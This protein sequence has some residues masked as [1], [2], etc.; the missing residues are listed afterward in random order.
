MEY[1]ADRSVGLYFSVLFATVA[2]VVGRGPA[3]SNL[4]RR[5][6]TRSGCRLPP[7]CGICGIGRFGA[8]R[9]RRTPRWW[10]G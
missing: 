10:R 4:R 1:I 7:M 3:V 5:L 9:R 2:K 6:S 8:R